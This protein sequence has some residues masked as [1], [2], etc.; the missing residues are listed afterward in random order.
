[1]LPTICKDDDYAYNCDKDCKTADN[2]RHHIFQCDEINR[3]CGKKRY[4]ER[5]RINV[6]SLI[7]EIFSAPIVCNLEIILTYVAVKLAVEFLLKR[8]CVN[9]SL[10]ACI[11][12]VEIG[13]SIMVTMAKYH[14]YDG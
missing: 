8:C 11:K 4:S 7:D 13:L 10:L 6:S 12:A 3:K 1:M 5:R 14:G 9:L 2:Q